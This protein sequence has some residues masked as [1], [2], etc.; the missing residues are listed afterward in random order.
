MLR[1][2]RRATAEVMFAYADEKGISIFPGKVSG[3]IAAYP[4]GP[5]TF[6]WD[7]I[8]IPQGHEKTWAEMHPDEKHETSMRK[9]ALEKLKSFL[10]KE[11][12]FNT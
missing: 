9:I 6:G 8:F 7:P 5:T 3:I 12:K 11:N 10:E 1:E 4:R 2:D